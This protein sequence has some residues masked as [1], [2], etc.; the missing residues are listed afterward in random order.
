MT[1]API[2]GTLPTVSID[3]DQTLPSRDRGLV[4]ESPLVD[5]REDPLLWQVP[6]E[7]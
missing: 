3:M 6:A 2:N 4:R 5:S 1:P 7:G